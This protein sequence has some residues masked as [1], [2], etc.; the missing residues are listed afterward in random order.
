MIMSEEEQRIYEIM[1]E[2]E[3]DIDVA[4]QMYLDEVDSNAQIR[5]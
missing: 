5:F 1:D 4:E 3:C 2:L